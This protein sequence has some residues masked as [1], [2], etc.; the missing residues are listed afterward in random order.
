MGFLSTQLEKL[1]ITG[2]Q[3]LSQLAE[4]IASSSFQDGDLL[5]NLPLDNRRRG[6]KTVVDLVEAT[7][8]GSPSELTQR[9]VTAPEKNLT[10]LGVEYD[11]EGRVQGYWVKKRHF[12]GT[13]RNDKAAYDFYPMYREFNGYRRRVTWLFKAP[14]NTRPYASRQ[15]PVMTPVITLFKY[16]QDYKE[17]VLIGAR[18][19]ACFSAFITSNNPAGAF[20][21][22]TTEAG[23]INQNPATQRRVTRLQPGTVTYLKPGETIDFA[24]PNRPGDN[25]DPFIK[26]LYKTISMYLRIPYEILFMDLSEANYSSWRGGA[27]EARKMANRWRRELTRVIRWVVNTLLFEASLSG[28]INGTV[29]DAKIVI[30][31]PSNGI[32]DPEK[33]ARGDK[34]RLENG[35]AS[36][37]MLADEQGL[38][39]DELREEILAEALEDLELKAEKL[40]KKKELEEK[41]DILI[42]DEDEGQDRDTSSSRRPNEEDGT[43]LDAEDAKERRKN[44]G[45]W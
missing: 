8:I 2:T 3:S 10:R 22:M 15:Y 24:S 39:Y 18:V 9:V 32:L 11:E 16:L 44:D 26:R 25:V 27:L 17:A 1:D 7:R 33:E 37:H 19:A 20:K 41:Y 42:S 40:K 4:T 21:A 45:N 6:V 23:R 28:E 36:R 30:R 35:T 31:W 29:A 14:L 5:I 13:G 12:V 38:D 34:L 43:D